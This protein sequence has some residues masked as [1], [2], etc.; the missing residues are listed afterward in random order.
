MT[1]PHI[2]NTTNEIVRAIPCTHNRRPLVAQLTVAALAAHTTRYNHQDYIRDKHIR[3]MTIRKA[4]RS[5]G[6]Y[7]PLRRFEPE[8]WELETWLKA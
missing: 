1:F 8:A 6:I 3:A 2:S 4:A 5:L 7:L